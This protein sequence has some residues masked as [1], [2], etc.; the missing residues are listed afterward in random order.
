MRRATWLAL[1]TVVLTG[2]GGVPPETDPLAPIPEDINPDQIVPAP[3]AESW[4]RTFENALTIRPA[5]GENNVYLAFS[6]ELAALR[7]LDGEPLW[8]VPLDSEISAAPVA[9]GA[10]VVVATGGD[11]DFPARVWWIA[12][13]SSIAA[14]REMERPPLEIGAV[15]GTVVYI[16]DSGVG[17]IA[18]GVE[19]RVPV[20]GPVTIDLSVEDTLALVTTSGGRLLALDT[21]DGE[22]R[23][24]YV[25][26]GGQLTRPAIADG[27][28]YFGDSEGRV[29]ALRA[30]NGG[31]LW[32]RSLGVN[33][34]GAPAV[35]EDLLWVAG[36]DAQLRIFKAGNGTLLHTMP[37]SSRNYLDMTT[38]DVWT[39]VGPQYGPW[40]AYRGPTRAESNRAPGRVGRP[41]RIQT[42][43]QAVALELPAGSGTAGIAVV[44]GEETLIFLQPQRGR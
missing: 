42:P 29:I 33:F 6:N 7:A 14:Q 37:L 23:W 44:N 15:P 30:S 39:V 22:L 5:V 8:S 41:V 40:V 36:L 12:N 26:D 20:E 31:R 32:D 13:D 24:D 11:D 28:V 25:A 21:D 16:D 35:T 38:F 1:V 17:R 3:L 9:L 18:G 27:R 19:W 43:G 10:Q 34:V 2:C 4:R